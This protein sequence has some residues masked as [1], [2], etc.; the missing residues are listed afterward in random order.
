[1]QTVNKH[2]D[3][4]LNGSLNRILP[5]IFQVGNDT[6]SITDDTVT[7]RSKDFFVGIINEMKQSFDFFRFLHGV[8]VLSSGD[9]QPGITE[10]N[11][12]EVKK[13]AM[14]ILSTNPSGVFISWI[15]HWCCLHG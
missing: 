13:T 10:M 6:S 1:M 8:D 7:Y 15:T 3:P 4:F 2:F 5:K 9:M 11:I 12:A 14:G